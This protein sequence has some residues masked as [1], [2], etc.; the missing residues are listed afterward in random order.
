MTLIKF[1]ITYS[2]SSFTIFIEMA[3][4]FTGKKTPQNKQ[5]TTLLLQ[6]S[7][8]LSKHKKKHVYSK[9]SNSIWV[10]VCIK[11]ICVITYVEDNL[12]GRH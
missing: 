11:L 3:D 7:S 5:K 4:L 12:V 9:C 10:D 6:F 8:K 1:S 2:R